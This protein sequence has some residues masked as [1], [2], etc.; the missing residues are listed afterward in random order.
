MG[1]ENVRALR[2]KMRVGVQSGDET[3]MTGDFDPSYDDDLGFEVDQVAYTGR[4]KNK[5][6]LFSAG[7]IYQHPS[8]SGRYQQPTLQLTIRRQVRVKRNHLGPRNGANGWF[9]E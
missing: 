1:P 4:I 2:N 8:Y 5:G 7:A 6:Q 9:Y 3:V